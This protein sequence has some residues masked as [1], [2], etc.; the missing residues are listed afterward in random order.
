MGYKEGDIF[1]IIAK[2][3]H[4]V[5]P[6]AFASICMG[7]PIN[8]LDTSF[9]K[10]EIMHMLSITKPKLMFCDVDRYDL[11]RECLNELENEATVFTFSG[12]T[13]ESIPVET[14]FEESTEEDCFA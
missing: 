11:V 1:S 9:S 7:C 5:T 10:A 8:T 3:S 2:N 12:Q 13:N 14:L 4:Y 6:I